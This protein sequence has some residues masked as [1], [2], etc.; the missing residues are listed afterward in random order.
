[1]EVAILEVGEKLYSMPREL[2][3][4]HESG[5]LGS[6][7]PANQ[8]VAYVQKSNN[9]L[10]VILGTLVNICLCDLHCLGIALQ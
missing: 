5:F 2:L 6:T 10:K 7:K 4:Q 1:M 3:H 8:L 9:G